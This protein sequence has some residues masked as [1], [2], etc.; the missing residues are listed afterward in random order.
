MRNFTP[1]KFCCSLDEKKVQVKNGVE[2]LHLLVVTHMSVCACD[3]SEYN[4]AAGPCWAC[5]HNNCEPCC[6]EPCNFMDG[7]YCCLCWWCCSLCNISKYWAS[8]IEQPCSCVNHCL[9]IF[10][11]HIINQF[12]M[13]IPV[14]LFNM[15]L[16]YNA[17][18]EANVFDTPDPVDRYI[19]D[20]FLPCC[21]LTAPCAGCQQLRAV[22]KEHWDCCGQLMGDQG[23]VCYLPEWKLMRVPQ[24][25]TMQ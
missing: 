16:R 23:F 21:C 25:K 6:G 2:I 18:L 20:C 4:E 8:Q 24:A 10:L 17:R 22:P 5:F 9:I 3:W 19:G 15:M 14:I 13:G 1:T 12:L 11:I 7:L